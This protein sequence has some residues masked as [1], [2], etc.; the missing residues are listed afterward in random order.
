MERYRQN[1]HAGPGQVKLY[2]PELLS[3][4]QKAV[5]GAADLAECFREV[6]GIFFHRDFQLSE[7]ALFERV[8]VKATPDTQERLSQYLDVVETCLLKQISSRSQHFFEALTTLQDV[9]DRLAQACRQVLRL[10]AG[11]HDIDRKTVMG[12]IRIPRLAQRKVNLALLLEKL[13][14]IQDVQRSKGLVQS[15]LSAGDYMGA[16]DVLEDGRALMREG[17]LAAVHCMRKLDRQLGEYLELVS[18]LMGSSFINL[19]VQFQGEEGGREGVK[20][21]G[22]G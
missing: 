12:M 7:P 17:G 15:L 10:R 19:A 13:R 20:G 18:D 2:R 9:R 16:L 4:S 8:V 21:G 22:G 11:L 14:L 3:S 1:H 6:P 5:D